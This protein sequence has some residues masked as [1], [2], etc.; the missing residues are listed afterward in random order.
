M[1]NQTYIG[2]PHARVARSAA[3]T[4]DSTSASGIE[5]NPYYRCYAS[6]SS[7]RDDKGFGANNLE[8]LVTNDGET[9]D[10]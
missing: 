5:A 4:F 7:H 8:S 2:N 10:L 9:H 1:D 3:N 6:P